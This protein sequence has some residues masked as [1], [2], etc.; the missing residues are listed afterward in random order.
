MLANPAMALVPLKLIGN[1]T[2]EWN[3]FVDVNNILLNFKLLIGHS[4]T[5]SEEVLIL[6]YI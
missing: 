4:Q 1:K 2:K 5:R 3:R 6:G